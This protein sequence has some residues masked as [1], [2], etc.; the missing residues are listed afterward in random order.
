MSVQTSTGPLIA[1][2]VEGTFLETGKV[3][4]LLVPQLDTVCRVIFPVTNAVENLT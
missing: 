4:M 1:P 2:G 3:L